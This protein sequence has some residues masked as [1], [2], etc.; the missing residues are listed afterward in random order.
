MT[1]L[2]VVA[3]DA[4]RGGDAEDECGEGQGD[5]EELK[6]NLGRAT[7]QLTMWRAASAGW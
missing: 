3:P 7:N 5:K 4:E 2:L 1:E 6:A